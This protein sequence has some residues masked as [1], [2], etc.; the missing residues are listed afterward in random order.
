MEKS[1]IW[2]VSSAEEV[3]IIARPVEERCQTKKETAQCTVSFLKAI[4]VGIE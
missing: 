3:D 2:N 4:F 1:R